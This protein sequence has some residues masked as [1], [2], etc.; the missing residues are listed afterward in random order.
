MLVI[1]TQMVIMRCFF[2]FQAEDGIRDHAQSRGLGDVYKR[3]SL[4]P[5]ENP[6]FLELIITLMSGQCVFRNSTESSVEALSAIITS[7]YGV[8]YSTTLG[9]KSSRNFLPFQLSITTAI[10]LSL[11]HI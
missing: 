9:R 5:L 4:Y 1:R 2:F 6:P 8:L 7:A 3:Q 11:I 10:F